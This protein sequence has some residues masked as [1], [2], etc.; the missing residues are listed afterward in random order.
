MRRS[1]FVIILSGSLL[2][3]VARAQPVEAN[4]I[5]QLS[6]PKENQLKDALADDEQKTLQALEESM[7]SRDDFDKT[8]S[9]PELTPAIRAALSKGAQDSQ[10]RT[11]ELLRSLAD[12]VDALHAKAVVE[13]TTALATQ[14][15]QRVVIRGSRTIYNF[16]DGD[17]YEVHA[18]VD[19]V[20]DIELEPGEAIT[21]APTS[22]DT[23]RW[24]IAAM[25][26]GGPPNEITHLVIKPLE[27]NIETN[28]IVTTNRRVYHLRARS[29]E[30]HMPA[31]SWN[32]PGN[33]AAAMAELLRKRQSEEH[34]EIAP[35]QLDFDYKVKGDSYPWKPA[36]V[37]DDGKK[38]YLRMPASMRVAE[39]PVLFVISEDSDSTLVNYRVKGDFYI[40]DRLFD[41]A[42]LRVGVKQKVLIRSN[43]RVHRSFFAEL[44][45]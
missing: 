37:F 36:A 43:K 39:A 28:I 7:P 25:Q 41:E 23:V 17:V 40:V 42:E 32:Y 5:G 31:I 2:S 13:R 24:S 45:G 6:T 30:F 34:I 33:N 19:H 14:K 16:K 27:E 29:G 12:E 4:K 10:K 15:P 35:E 20:T 9:A 44:F 11:D 18:G 38:T 3:A 1:L 21:S 26:S 8:E 22:G